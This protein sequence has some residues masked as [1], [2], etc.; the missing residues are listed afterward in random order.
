[1]DLL[2]AFL[3]GVLQGVTEFLP[4]SSSGHLVL[5]EAL[6]GVQKHGI[7]FEVAVHLATAGAVV[8]AY[9]RRIRSM[10][11]AL[12]LLVKP[13]LW[14]SHR[15]S[16]EAGRAMRE[17][18]LLVCYLVVGSVPAAIVGLLFKDAVESAFASPRLV[19]FMLITTGV[20]LASS[21]FYRKERHLPLL[22]WK[23]LLI[24][25]VQAAALLPG[26]SRSGITI[27][28][29]LLL[30]LGPGKA[31]EFSFLLALPAII[32]ASIVELVS[33]LNSASPMI[34]GVAALAVGSLAAFFSGFT[35]I[36]ILLKTLQKGSFHGFAYYCWAVGLVGIIFI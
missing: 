16:D 14:P 25:I 6:L 34:D 8:L 28:A 23:A 7:T 15:A 5:G 3:L 32:G 26:I 4:I 18:F 19:C 22:W 1:M 33:I 10:L 21:R 9:R 36:F 29:G 31:A 24:G 27:T 11:G 20:I 12:N 30:G 13:R 35:A 17:N 2:A